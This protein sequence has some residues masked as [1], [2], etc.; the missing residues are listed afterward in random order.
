MIHRF[1]IAAAAALL[2][3]GTAAIA[4]YPERPIRILVPFPPGGNVDITARIVAPGMSSQ[5]GQPVIIDNRGGAHGTIAAEIVAK[6]AR[7]GY[8]LMLA[9]SGMLAIAPALYQKLTYD[10]V[11]DFA[12]IGAISTVPLVM[13]VHPSSPATTVRDFI[14]AAKSRPGRITMA[15]NGS[16]STPDLAGALFQSLTGTKLIAVPYKGSGPAQIDLAGGQV[17]VYFDQLSAAIAFVNGG[18]TRALA[19]TS[20]SRVAQLP[21]VPTMSEAGVPGCEATTFTGLL[22]PAGTS[23]EIVS[24]LNAALNSALRTAAVRESFNRFAGQ[25]LEGTPEDLAR[26][27]RDE[28]AKWTKVVRAAGIKAE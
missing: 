4:A 15:T 14:A 24:K 9:S 27:I 21:D 5:L 16:G 26:L 2:M 23:R 20:K 12:P 28:T 17:E 11:R 18:K 6:A 8:T 7:D 22:A 1:I 3:L 10:I 25:T 13:L 19:V